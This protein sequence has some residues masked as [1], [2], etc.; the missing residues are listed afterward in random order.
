MARAW[1]KHYR[2]MSGKTHCEAGVAF[3]TLPNHGTREFMATCPCFSQTGL[4]QLAIYPTAEE[5]AAED[6]AMRKRI[7]ATG[8]ARDA[9]VQA[10]GGPWR[11]GMPS[12]QGVI[13]CPVCGN[14]NALQFI[15]SGYNGHIHAAC[16]TEGCVGW[17]E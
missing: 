2:G 6:A 13:A 16:K 1:C 17:M 3:A 11:R 15:R 5:M 4:C 14:A 7:E 9:I 12:R 10:C 8:T